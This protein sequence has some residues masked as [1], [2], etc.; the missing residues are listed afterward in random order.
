QLV[1]YDAQFDH[2]ANLEN[3]EVEEKFLIGRRATAGALERLAC[4]PAG[5]VYGI[6]EGEFG[7]R[8]QAWDLD[9]R[10]LLREQSLGQLLE[11]CVSPDGRYLALVKREQVEVWDR[12]VSGE[13][14]PKE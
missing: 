14:Q 9:A 11:L 2:V 4:S 3:P 12:W 5:V 6:A 8:L 7:C 10:S 13:W 1:L